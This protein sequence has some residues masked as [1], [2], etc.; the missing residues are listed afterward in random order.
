MNAP[1]AQPKPFAW[2]YSKLKNLETCERRFNEVDILKRFKEEE[3]ENLSWGNTLH[4]A[5]AKA[6]RGQ[7]ELPITLRKY[8]TYVDLAAKIAAKGT[9]DTERKLAFDRSFRPVDFFDRS[10]WFRSVADVLFLVG[11]MGILWDWKT[12]KILDD[13][14]QLGLSATTVFA[15]YPELERVQTVFVWIGSDATTEKVWTKAD[16]GSL[17]TDVMPRVRRLENAVS[18]N[19]FTPMPGGL[20]KRYCPVTSCEYHGKGSH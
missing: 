2:S 18:T 11:K 8:Q 6:I 15:H 1:V 14:V 4:D 20:C 13:S 7:K 19:S 5:M 3:S 16:L 17:W 12:G 10:A 9:V